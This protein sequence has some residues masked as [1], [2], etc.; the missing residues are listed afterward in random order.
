M[1]L[2]NV[3]CYHVSTVPLDP[4]QNVTV[5]VVSSQSI[6]ISW[7]SPILTEQNGDIVSYDVR[8]VDLHENNETN[9]NVPD[10]NITI[11]GT[12]HNVLL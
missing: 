4:P 8:V 1:L 9:R 5:E 12:V 2:F 6:Y 7:E 3:L 10:R 11:E